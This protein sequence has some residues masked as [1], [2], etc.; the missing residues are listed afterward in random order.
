MS[1]ALNFERKC[2]T[3]GT[4][5][6][7]L[8]CG[9][10]IFGSGLQLDQKI[11]RYLG[12]NISLHD[13]LPKFLCA[14]CFIKVESIDKF[15]ILAKKTE[16]AYL[17]WFKCI[18]ANLAKH[19]SPLPP[20]LAPV[21]QLLTIPGPGSPTPG[22][23]I[24]PKIDFT[25]LKQAVDEQ[26]KQN[27]APLG[28]A[29]NP[30]RL[31][32]PEISIVSYSDLK[33][34][35]LI[36]DQELLKLILKALRW[37]EHDQRATFEVL[38][39]R[40]KNT[41]FREILSNPNLLKDS[42][43]TQLLK[44]Y[45]GQEAFNKF[46]GENGNCS[47]GSSIDLSNRGVTIKPIV[48]ISPVKAN[49]GQQSSCSMV[50]PIVK[51]ERIPTNEESLTQMEVGIDP[52][53]FLDDE[54]SL[55]KSK[56]VDKQNMENV[57]TIQLVPAKM[58]SKLHEKKI[59]P[60]TLSCKVRSIASC[61]NAGAITNNAE[62]E[63]KSAAKPLIKSNNP[64]VD[65]KVIKIRVKKNKE[66]IQATALPV[67]IPV[68]PISLPISIPPTT[69]I[70]MIPVKTAELKPEE[71]KVLPQANSPPPI[72][73][74]NLQKPT[75]PAKAKNEK[76]K[77]KRDAKWT[78]KL[79]ANS[80]KRTRS[81]AGSIKGSKLVCNVCKKRFPS[82]SKLTAHMES[83][84]KPIDK[85]TCDK[86]D[87]VFR[88]A[89]N[90]AKHKQFHG[91]EKFSCDHCRKVYAT[92]SMLKTHK[93]SHSNDRPHRCTICDKTFKR[94]QDL[95]FHQ[96]QHTGSRPFKCPQCPKSFA[97]SG[98]CF[99]HRKRMHPSAAEEKENSQ[100]VGRVQ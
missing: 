98:N 33:L 28:T 96:N 6:L 43:L 95:K 5:I 42:D 8:T 57:V 63:Y 22:M 99:S 73:A 27:D 44:S 66:K 31:I 75:E 30:I 47:A 65:K 1:L 88:T 53:L 60:T 80:A 2:R 74:L 76:P 52:N 82:K 97:S 35:L 100:K 79:G 89:A 71:E 32:K 69:T 7:E 23:S 67:P 26:I 78:L 21:R 62:L 56:P 93:L 39:Q 77:R 24:T 54:E 34:G 64:P 55:R 4:D 45:I 25:A 37:A 92:S 16:E 40:L 12:L 84:P 13:D 29:M 14:T 91:G 81:Q 90:L 11:H 49:P 70:T 46:T 3:C 10:P 17:G 72:P 15:A 61:S 94:N 87:R 85:Y 83:H 48:H 59:P 41:T 36:K 38:I 20:P 51:K 58:T 19:I 50:L 68:N 86:C 18:R 9:I